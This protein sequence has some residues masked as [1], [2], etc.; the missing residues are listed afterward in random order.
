[1]QRQ[2]SFIAEICQN[3]IWQLRGQ[4]LATGHA[5]VDLK[6]RS[7]PGAQR[8]V[9]FQLEAWTWQAAGLPMRTSGEV[10]YSPYNPTPDANRSFVRCVKI[11]QAARGIKTFTFSRPESSNGRIPLQPLRYKPGQFGSFNFEA[12]RSIYY[13]ACTT[14]CTPSAE[15]Y[16]ERGFSDCWLWAKCVTKYYRELQCARP[17][18][19]THC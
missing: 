1:M 7:L 5:R 19:S 15:C 12:S 18:W 11:E 10:E 6:D 14:S 2:S 4:L 16:T 13:H 3:L 9:H 17:I 8:S